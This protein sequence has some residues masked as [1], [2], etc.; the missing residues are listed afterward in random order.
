[1][2]TS[3]VSIM[4]EA[5]SCLEKTTD[6]I[7]GPNPFTNKTIKVRFFSAFHVVI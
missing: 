4:E 1:M 5:N 3:S 7:L 2:E 6:V